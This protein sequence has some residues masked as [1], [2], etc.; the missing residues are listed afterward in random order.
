MTSRE[1]IPRLDPGVISPSA[2]KT[3]N[4]QQPQNETLADVIERALFKPP[5]PPVSVP[6]TQPS[7]VL[8]SLK[9]AQDVI[10]NSTRNGDHHQ[11]T[12]VYPISSLRPVFEPWVTQEDDR[13]VDNLSEYEAA[14]QESEGQG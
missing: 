4:P 8:D 3:D 7:V 13:R 9:R 5:P 14:A 2:Q 11:R 10:I 1:P 6:H 12:T